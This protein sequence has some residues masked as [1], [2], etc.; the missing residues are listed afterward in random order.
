MEHNSLKINKQTKKN[1]PLFDEFATNGNNGNE[2]NSSDDI[3][4]E[5]TCIHTGKVY[6]T[7]HIINKHKESSDTAKM[8]ERTQHQDDN[9]N[10]RKRKK[11]RKKCGF[12]SLVVY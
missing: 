3:L 7:Q 1:Y 10:K 9:E 8:K 2:S 4:L 12:Y 6:N 5:K 11:R